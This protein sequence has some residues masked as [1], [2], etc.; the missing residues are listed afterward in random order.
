MGRTLIEFNKEKCNALDVGA[1]VHQK[2][3]LLEKAVRIF[4]WTVS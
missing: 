1:N 4:Q 2:N 3:S